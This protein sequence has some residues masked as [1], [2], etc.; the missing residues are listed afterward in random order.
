MPDQPEHQKS[1]QV[2]YSSPHQTGETTTSS[3]DDLAKGLASGTLSR[4]KA[5]RLLG[6]ALVGGALASLPGVAWA[7]GGGNS[8]CVR[9]CKRAFEPGEKI[10]VRG[11]ERSARGYCIS[12]SAKNRQCYVPCEDNGN[13]DC[14]YGEE[15]CGGE[16][17]LKCPEGQ[18]RDFSTCVCSGEACPP[19]NLLTPVGGGDP[20]CA[21]GGGCVAS[22]D[23]CES[24]T[25][26]ASG[27]DF[28]GSNPPPITLTCI[29]VLC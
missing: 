8:A 24:G 15:L 3:F 27:G 18:V 13:G 29:N 6:G 22:C 12:Q 10:T 23:E 20:I 9:C 14:P 1:S 16:C 17:V 28:C 5:L 26:C 7:Q 25:I 21:C 2:H 19:S 4:G 11:R